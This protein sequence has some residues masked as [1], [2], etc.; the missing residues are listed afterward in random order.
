MA[1][2]P[3]FFPNFSL[4]KT[5]RVPER[6]PC[7]AP[8]PRGLCTGPGREPLARARVP[9]CQ[10]GREPRRSLALFGGPG[11]GRG[12]RGRSGGTFVSAFAKGIARSV[13]FTTCGSPRGSRNGVSGCGGGGSGPGGS[14]Q[15]VCNLGIRQRLGGSGSE[16][17]ATPLL[18]L[19]VVVA[20]VDVLETGLLC[21][22]D[23]LLF[24]WNS[25]GQK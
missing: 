3:F 24:Y 2:P 7:Q 19:V 1:V 20:L 6:S 22:Y 21:L 18:L 9:R 10:A 12:G 14:G 25:R 11:A 16:G 13:G 17:A 8:A 5:L 4:V 23:A 15:G